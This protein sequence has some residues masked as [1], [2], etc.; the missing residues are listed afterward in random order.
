MARKGMTS[1]KQESL[2]EVVQHLGLAVVER[3]GWLKCYKADE[4]GQP[5]G[6]PAIGI[7]TTKMVTRVELVNF[8]HPLGVPHPKP[9]AGSVTQMLNFEQDEKAIRK[10]LYKVC[11][12]GILGA[13]PK[14]KPEA[15]EAGEEAKPGSEEALAQTASESG[16]QAAEQGQ[17]VAADEGPVTT[18]DEAQHPADSQN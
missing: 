16:E 2:L 7:P 13:K 15:S 1:V 8:E 6:K 5:T 3:K 10:D 11:R 14:A 12:E 4:K 18:A 17:Q 9:P